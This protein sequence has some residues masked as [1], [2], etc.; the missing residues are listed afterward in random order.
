MNRDDE[1]RLLMVAYKLQKHLLEQGGEIS[2][3]NSD[4]SIKESEQCDCDLGLVKMHV[5]N[6]YPKF[7]K[8]IL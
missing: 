4:C 3:H 5:M 8:K 1:K 2:Y 6:D 7:W